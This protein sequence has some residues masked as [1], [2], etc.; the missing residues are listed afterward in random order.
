MACF[1]GH[2]EFSPICIESDLFYDDHDKLDVC[3][4]RYGIIS[5]EVNNCWTGDPAEG[6][7]IVMRDSGI[8]PSRWKIGKTK[9]FLKEP[10]TVSKLGGFFC[11]LV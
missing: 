5:P 6:C 10:N 7:K 3:I 11:F 4:F 2:N 1:S 9:L 8:D